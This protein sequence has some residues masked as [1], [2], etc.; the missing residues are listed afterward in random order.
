MTALTDFC[1]IPTN[2]A[3]G[4]YQGTPAS[5]PENPQRQVRVGQS[6][7]RPGAERR[8]YDPQQPFTPR[9]LPCVVQRPLDQIASMPAV[10]PKPTYA[11]LEAAIRIELN[12]K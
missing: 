4:C 5:R 11:P 1:V 6:H 7:P 10:D 9:W 2:P 3:N 12:D 8:H